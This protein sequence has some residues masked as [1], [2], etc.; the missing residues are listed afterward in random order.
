MAEHRM[1]GVVFRFA[2]GTMVLSH[3]KLLRILDPPI[4]YPRPPSA[5]TASLIGRHFIG[6]TNLTR[7]LTSPVGP[8]SIMGPMRR[9]KQTR[10][11]LG[12]RFRNWTVR[13]TRLKAAI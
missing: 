9:E 11:L 12:V 2:P 13:L 5:M 10:G 1:L 4:A 6:Q 7:N 3:T 8:V